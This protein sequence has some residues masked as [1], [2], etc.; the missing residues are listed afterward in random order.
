MGGN[1]KL[2]NSAV[3]VSPTEFRRNYRTVPSLCLAFACEIL[4]Q[5]QFCTTNFSWRYSSTTSTKHKLFSSL[6]HVEQQR[7]EISFMVCNFLY[8]RC[9][10]PQH[11]KE[12]LH[13][14]SS[15]SLFFFCLFDKRKMSLSFTLFRF[16]LCCRKKKRKKISF[17]QRHWKRPFMSSVVGVES[18]SAKFSC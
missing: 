17:L 1:R 3:P 15:C 4:R 8:R 13:Y 6:L 16:A 2:R 10:V 11:T 9:K 5:T 7:E 14:I 18:H 12:F